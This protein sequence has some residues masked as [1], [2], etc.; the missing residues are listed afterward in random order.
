MED[1]YLK[2]P[3]LRNPLPLSIGLQRV[4]VELVMLPLSVSDVCHLLLSLLN[5]KGKIWFQILKEEKVLGL[6][7]SIGLLVAHLVWESSCHAKDPGLNP[8]LGKSAGE[9][10]R[11]HL[12][13]SWGFSCSSAGKIRLQ[14]GDLD[15]VLGWKSPLE[16][17]KVAHS[18]I[19][20]LEE[21]MDCIV[22]QGHKDWTL[23][24]NFHFLYNIYI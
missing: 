5:F 2:A 19:P 14:C 16:K 12:Q 17:E 3:S 1:G 22:Q 10:M 9:R 21:I 8:G 23:L 11:F 18:S 15:G 7:Y 24:R 4:E 6:L 13:Y 20:G